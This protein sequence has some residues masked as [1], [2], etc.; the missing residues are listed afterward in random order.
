[1]GIGENVGENTGS[2]TG[3]SGYTAPPVI[4]GWPPYTPTHYV[5]VSGAGSHNGSLGNEWTLLEACNNVTAG[6][7]VEVASGTYTDSLATFDQAFEPVNSGTSVNQI[8]FYSGVK[9]GATLS[10]LNSGLHAVSMKNISYITWDGFS[11]VGGLWMFTGTGNVVKNNDCN[12]GSIPGGDP[13]LGTCIRCEDQQSGLVRNNNV[14]NLPNNGNTSHN[15]AGIMVIG[16]NNNTIV[17]YNSVDMTGSSFGGPYG[18]KGGNASPS[19]NTWRYNFGNGGA[20]ASLVLLGKATGQHLATVHNNVFINGNDGIQMDKISQ[21]HTIYNNT[22]Y[23]ANKGIVGI[24]GCCQGVDTFNNIFA[25]SG[26]QHIHWISNDHAVAACT[27]TGDK[28]WS[29]WL[30]YMDYNNY[31]GSPTRFA[32]AYPPN[33]PSYA[34]MAAFTSA[35][36]FDTNSTDSTAPGFINAGG[37]DPEDY[38]RSSYPTDGRGGIYESVM[39]AYVTGNETIGYT[40]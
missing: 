2:N 14:Y 37:T 32:S 6:N 23:S 36:G 20:I 31:S 16:N 21:D 40:A 17:E 33:N 5:T 34:T 19:N 10:Q 29:T 9:H 11:I 30:D 8:I 18:T 7:I 26:T 3:S 38:K 12:G 39:G 27:S 28:P 22:V 13:S 1:M 15:S 24:N 35:Q 25:E 4:S